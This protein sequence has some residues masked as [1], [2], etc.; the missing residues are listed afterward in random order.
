M[1]I[2]RQ[3]SLPDRGKLRRRNCVGSIAEFPLVVFILLLIITFPLIDLISLGISAATLALLTQQAASRAAAQQ[4]YSDA[5]SSMQQEALGFLAQGFARLN[6]MQPTGGYQNCG[7]ELYTVA[8]DFHTNRVSVYGPNTSLPSPPQILE[9]VYEFDCKAKY[10]VG[11][12]IS[13]AGIPGF[14]KIPGLGCPAVLT[15]NCCRSLEHPEGLFTNIITVGAIAPGAHA[16]PFVAQ[17]GSGS[18]PAPGDGSW[19]Y[20]D[21]Y[22]L[23]ANSG[24]T[25]LSEDVLVVDANNPNWTVSQAL[26]P[27]GC[28][29][30]IDT[31]AN[32]QWSLGSSAPMTDANGATWSS[33][34]GCPIGSLISQVGTNGPI[35]ESGNTL[36][37]Y[38]APSSGLVMF[39]NNDQT[40][41]YGDDL[42]TM[43]VRVIVTQ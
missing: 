15:F 43:T 1:H 40:G 3:V 33:A 13:L 22:Q 5:L 7:L 10:A 23:I 19:N 20:P 17:V 37:N 25:I 26:C 18:T 34:N 16:P 42:G 6:K 30:W 28:Q 41:E 32:G 29:V 4:N 39:R 8:T 14:D 12:F 9:Y 38:L 36:L 2:F 31:H 27:I 21:L 24:K 11:P 35:F